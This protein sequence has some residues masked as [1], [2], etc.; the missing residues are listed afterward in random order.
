MGFVWF[1]LLYF[2]MLGIG[3]AVLGSAAGSREVSF[4]EGYQAGYAKGQK[5]ANQ[6]R[7]LILLVAIGG[8]AIGTFTGRLPGTKRKVK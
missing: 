7:E 6:Y 3:G 5:F 1:L 2:G 8:A 4:N